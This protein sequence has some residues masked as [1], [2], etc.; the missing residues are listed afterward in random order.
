MESPGRKTNRGRLKTSMKNLILSILKQIVQYP[1]QVV[2][3]EKILG[4]NIVNYAIS[5]N[6]ED[7]GKVIGKEG[8]IIQAIR[9]VVKILAIKEGK[10]IYI[11]VT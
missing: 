3:E 7:T 1:D 11:E 10:Q 2:V 6:K 8:K 4:E 5:T 9:N